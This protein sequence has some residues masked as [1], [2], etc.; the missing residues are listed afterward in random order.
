M[1]VNKEMLQKAFE[2]FRDVMNDYIDTEIQKAHTELS[3]MQK[4]LIQAN[5]KN[6][7]LKFKNSALEAEN[8]KL[9]KQLEAANKPVADPVKDEVKAININIDDE[10]AEKLSKEIKDMLDSLGNEDSFF[11][12]LLKGF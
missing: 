5:D 4:Q 8:E 9:K 2:Q 1:E 3:A 6:A 11:N 12:K 10:T 7:D